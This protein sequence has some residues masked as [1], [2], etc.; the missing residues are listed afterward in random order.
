MTSYVKINLT[1]WTNYQMPFNMLELDFI[2]K[3]L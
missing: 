1:L 3:D 2:A